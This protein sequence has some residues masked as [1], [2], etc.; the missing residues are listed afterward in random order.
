[1]SQ[2]TSRNGRV[3]PGKGRLLAVAVTALVTT[4]VPATGSPATLVDSDRGPADVFWRVHLPLGHL[5][6]VRSYQLVG[7]LLCATCSDGAVRTLRPDTG[8]YLWT[9]EVAR[10]LETL[11]PPVLWQ[12]PG[13]DRLVVTLAREAVALDPATGREVARIPLPL[14]SMTP[15]ALSRDE[16]YQVGPH[17]RML[18]LAVRNGLLL[19]QSGLSRHVRIAPLYVPAVDGVVLTDVEGNVGAVGTDKATLFHRQL[20]GPAQG[21]LA[22]DGAVVFVATSSA[23]LYALDLSHGGIQWKYRLIDQPV[24]GPVV[25]RESV[26]QATRKGLHRIGL[27]HRTPAAPA[28]PTSAPSTQAAESVADASAAVAPPDNV[29]APDETET[30]ERPPKTVPA[31]TVG[32]LV[33]PQFG[34][35]WI[36][37][38][39]VQFLAEWPQGTVVLHANGRLALVSSVTGKIVE[40]AETITATAGVP[41]PHGDAV[42]LTSTKGEV[43]CVRPMR[44]PPLTVAD[45]RA[46]PGRVMNREKSLYSTRLGARP[47]KSEP[48]VKTEV[49]ASDAASPSPAASA[50]AEEGDEAKTVVVPSRTSDQMLL[51]DPL[52]SERRLRK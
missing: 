49:A 3:L 21:W 51:L 9:A 8:E 14:T 19:W 41:N 16:V 45:F 36:D 30:M 4:G 26:Y 23:D 17:G 43:R 38:E 33:P 47:D 25:T 10:E 7:G 46:S 13:G 20:D 2:Q 48:A 5:A 52:R 24:G 1:M 50:P 15:V 6:T 12:A 42:L 31:D 40:F 35:S 44:A 34:I 39:A 28:A 29:P 37:P 18:C 22:S 32:R 27:A 11:H